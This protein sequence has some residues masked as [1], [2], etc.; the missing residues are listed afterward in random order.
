MNTARYQRQVMLPQLGTAGQQ[1]LADAKVLV[2]G[3]GGLGCPALLYLTAAGV[4]TLGIVDHDRVSVSNLHRQVLYSEADIGQWKAEKAQQRLLAQNP[5]LTCI[6]HNERLHTGNVFDLLQPYDLVID[7][8]DNFDTRYLLN[9][10]C[11]L[12][13]KPLIFGAIARFEGQVAVF[14][15]RLPDGGRSANYRDLFPEPPT[16]GSVPNCAEAGVIGVLPG[17]IGTLQATEAIK[18]ITG[19]G[20]PLANALHTY[21]VLDNHSFTLQIAPRPDTA[22]RIPTTRAALEAAD[23]G[24]YCVAP[25]AGQPLGVSAQTL[26]HWLAQ[27]EQVRVIDIRELHEEPPFTLCTHER[28]PVRDLGEQHFEAATVVLVCQSGQR[29]MA[30]ARQWQGAGARVFSLEGGLLVT[31]DE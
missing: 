14:N 2:V 22:Q 25:V 21:S 6:V 15:L 20:T 12:V 7:G 4:G 16:P 13:G 24:A 31:S 28:V 30:A 26:L 19:I 9:D 27:G 18:M 8:T 10:A 3:A 23:Y 1:K 29:S 11:V 5:E 17:I